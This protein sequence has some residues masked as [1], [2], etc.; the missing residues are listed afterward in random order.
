MKS[1]TDYVAVFFSGMGDRLVENDLTSSTDITT[2]PKVEHFM[3][4]AL[5]AEWHDSKEIVA[6]KLL[7]TA[8]TIA[9]SK[10]IKVPD[11]LASGRAVDIAISADEAIDS[12][13]GAYKVAKGE[14]SVTD[15]LEEKAKKVIARVEAVAHS[16]IDKVAEVVKSK[17]DVL[18]DKGV[19]IV[20]NAVT[21]ICPPAKV[22]APVV[23][24][25]AKALA[26]PVK[27]FIFKGISKVAAGAKRLVS[28]VG[29]KARTVVSE[30][31]ENVKK[32][33]SC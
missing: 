5:N 8:A 23:K 32:S 25:A 6:K 30:V 28:F 9:K 7:T 26:Q 33:T 24:A 13:K 3:E 11:A 20:V 16:T 21:S 1:L 18:V 15:F 17:L 22:L 10:G 14:I 4:M 12:L 29:D 27:R 2:T 31:K 19:D